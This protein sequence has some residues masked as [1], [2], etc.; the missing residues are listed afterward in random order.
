MD[1]RNFVN[2]NPSE[3]KIKKII[4]SVI[5]I[6]I[7]IILGFN[8]FSVVQPGHTGV[9]VTLGKVSPTVFEEGFHFKIPFIS[10][11]V[12]IDNRV[13]KTE[14]QSNAAS[15]DLQTIDS[16]VS[17]NYRVNKSSSADIYKNVGNDFTN[18][19]VNPAIQEC[20]KSI[21]AKYTA[22]Q[23]ITNRAVVSSE[24]EEAIS[25]KINPYG[26]SI[27]VFNIINFDFTEEFN[28]A[29]E[30]KQT[31]QQEALKAEQDLARIKVEAEQTVEKAKAEAEAYKLKNEQLTETVIMM[32]FIDKWNGELPKVVSDTSSLFDVS[33]YI[34]AAAG[35][36]SLSE[37]S[38]E[39]TDEQ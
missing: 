9:V 13:M 37:E 39:K 2:V 25:Q 8:S 18:V 33:S 14:V 34:G 16:T 11:V 20:V 21:A 6:L 5:V 30:A 35:N 29:I 1:S 12:Q 24:M 3:K 22:E 28:K 38:P 26:M 27:E 23:L 4:V 15:K 10:Q 19:I 7:V 32:E 31:A 17:V 36:S